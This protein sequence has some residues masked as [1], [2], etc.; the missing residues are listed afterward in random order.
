MGEYSLCPDLPQHRRCLRYFYA[1]PVSQ[2]GTPRAGRGRL[3]RR[4]ILLPDLQGCRPAAGPT[5]SAHSLHPAV[6]G[7]VE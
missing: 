2:G 7:D 6:P 5:G 4:R 3:Y 1:D